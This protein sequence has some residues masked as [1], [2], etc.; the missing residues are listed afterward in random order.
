[1]FFEEA[2]YRLYRDWLMTAAREYA[3]KIHAYVFMTNHVHLLVTPETADSLPRT[4]QS[5]GRRYVRYVNTALRRYD[6]LSPYYL[7]LFFA[8]FFDSVWR[9]LCRAPL[10]FRKT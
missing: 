9:V 8:R 2:D 7:F 10:R 6:N 4:M 5:L 1:V 3:A